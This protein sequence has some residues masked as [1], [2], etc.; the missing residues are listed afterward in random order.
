MVNVDEHGGTY[1]HVPP[2]PATPPDPA[3]PAGQLGFRYP[4]PT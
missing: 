2:P 1:D 3:A 4:G